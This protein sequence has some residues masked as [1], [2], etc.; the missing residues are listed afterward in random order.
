MTEHLYFSLTKHLLSE[1]PAQFAIATQSPFLLAAAH[2][3]LDKDTLRSWLINDR[4][5]IHAYIVHPTR[6]SSTEASQH[7]PRG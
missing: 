2:G 1:S 7:W 5:Y 3:R 6:R 4:K